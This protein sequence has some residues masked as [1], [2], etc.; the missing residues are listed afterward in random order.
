MLL[1]F[2]NLFLTSLE[3][4]QKY[5][6]SIGRKYADTFAFS[7]ILHSNLSAIDD[8]VKADNFNPEAFLMEIDMATGGNSRKSVENM[9]KIFEKRR[10]GILNNWTMGWSPENCILNRFFPYEKFAGNRGRRR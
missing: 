8:S 2:I 5:S 6:W 1:Y 10:I 7:R 9:W 3:V 4:F